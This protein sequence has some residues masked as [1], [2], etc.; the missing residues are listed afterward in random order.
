MPSLPLTPADESTVRARVL[1]LRD[2]FAGPTAD[3]AELLCDEHPADAVAV[4]TVEAAGLVTVLTF[5]DLRRRSTQCARA[6]QELGVGRG[7]RVASLMDKG[8]DLVVLIVAIWRLGAVYVPLFTAFAQQA[9][10][11]RLEGSGARV[12]VVDP[13]QRHKLVP[14]DDLPADPQ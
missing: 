3:V 2:R 9:I 6:L 13:G 4:T 1:E 5:G 12:V 14:G 11:L 7:D 8:P 10:A